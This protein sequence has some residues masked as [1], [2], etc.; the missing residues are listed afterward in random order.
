M[1]RAV[2]AFDREMG[3]GCVIKRVDRG[4]GDWYGEVGIADWKDWDCGL[5]DC[6]Y[7]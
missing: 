3:W 2:G 1:L 4:R 5:S 7:G 6:F